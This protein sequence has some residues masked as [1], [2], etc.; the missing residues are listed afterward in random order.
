MFIASV[1]SRAARLKTTR[2]HKMTARTRKLV[3]WP[4]QAHKQV[5]SFDL[6]TN[7]EHVAVTDC[8]KEVANMNLLHASRIGAPA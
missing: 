2:A 8:D 7:I 3:A 1:E 5:H 6:S 4:P